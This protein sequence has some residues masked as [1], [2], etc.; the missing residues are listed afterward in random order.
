MTPA[1]QGNCTVTGAANISDFLPVAVVAEPRL[2]TGLVGV[3]AE[4]PKVSPGQ[5]DGSP[6][7]LDTCTGAE[8]QPP[9]TENARRYCTYPC[10]LLGDS[11]LT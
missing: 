3:S 1:V 11:Q 6:K 4:I 10:E 8:S 2:S 7:A 9:V 5:T